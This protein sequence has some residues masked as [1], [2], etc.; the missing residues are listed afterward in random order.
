MNASLS[1]KIMQPPL[2]SVALP[3]NPCADPPS[4]P[5]PCANNNSRQACCTC[6]PF[7]LAWR[8]ST[9][10]VHKLPHPHPLMQTTTAGGPAAPARLPGWPGAQALPIRTVHPHPHPH[11]QTTTTP[12]NRRRACCTRVTFWLGWRSSTSTG[13]GNC[14]RSQVCFSR[15]FTRVQGQLPGQLCEVP[16]PPPCC[17]ASIRRLR[18]PATTHPGWESAPVAAIQLSSPSAE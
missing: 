5:S 17:M 15:P 7:W 10:H 1:E 13:S 18:K 11:V 12:P 6:A 2:A 8:S 9:A 14:W 3:F 16:L 4:P